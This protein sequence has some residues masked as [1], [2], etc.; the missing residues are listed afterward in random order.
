MKAYTPPFSLTPDIL[1]LMQEIAKAIGN[2]EGRKLTE[3][4]IKLRR[5]NQIKTI[6]ASLA[7]EGNT[8][9]IEQITTILNGKMVIGPLQDILE[10]KNAIKVYDQLSSFN[11]LEIHDILQAHQLLMQGLIDESGMWRTKAVGILKG[12]AVSHV[13]PPAKRVPKLMED[14]LQFTKKSDLPWLLKACIFHYELEFIHPFQDGN[15]RIG[16][17]WQQLLL[18]NE[19]ELFVCIPIEILV[20]QRQQDYYHALELSDMAGESANFVKFSLSLILQALHDFKNQTVGVVE[21]V[22]S[23]LSYA[24]THF[25]DRWFS[26]KEYMIVQTNIASATASRDLAYGLGSEI[27]TK[28]GNKNQVLYKYLD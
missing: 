20:K 13:A 22:I 27:L 28:C 14:L 26:R 3:T 10:V 16:R 4:P 2:L 18:I 25:K 12:N 23:R 21:D 15:G 17:L 19:H 8:L 11:P 6:Q 1:Q 7:I 9:T 5:E 24:K